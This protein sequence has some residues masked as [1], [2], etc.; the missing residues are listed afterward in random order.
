[1]HDKHNYNG[2]GVQMI[3]QL[4]TITARFLIALLANKVFKVSVL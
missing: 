3:G 4:A 1:M 2:K